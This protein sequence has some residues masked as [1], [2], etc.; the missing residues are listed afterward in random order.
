[1]VIVNRLLFH[2]DK[3]HNIVTIDKEILSGTPVMKGTRV[4]V[5]LILE[6]FSLGWNLDEIKQSFPSVNKRKIALLVKY[7][8]EEFNH[9]AI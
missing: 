3:F 8:S 1:M 7:I 2:N 9:N 6:Y 4:P 5:S